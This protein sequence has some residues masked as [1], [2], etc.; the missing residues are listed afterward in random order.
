MKSKVLIILV[1]IFVAIMFL[2]TPANAW[3]GVTGLVSDGKDGQPWVHGGSITV[4]GTVAGASPP[5]AITAPAPINTSTGIYSASYTQAPDL[6][7]TVYI[8]ATFTNGGEG[9]PS[10]QVIT[11]TEAP[12]GSVPCTPD[13]QQNITLDTGPNAIELKDFSVTTQSSTNTWLPFV[14]LV[15]SVALVSSAVTVIR[16]RRA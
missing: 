1:V 14:L 4:Y 7:T 5:I 12:S 6:F 13:Y 8:V 2:P 11:I 16:K 3:C 15:G 9:T 10:N